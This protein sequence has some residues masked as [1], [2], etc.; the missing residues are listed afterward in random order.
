MQPIDEGRCLNPH[1]TSG[2]LRA[3]AYLFCAACCK[4]YGMPDPQPPTPD[5]IRRARGMLASVRVRIE[6]ARP[7]ALGC[8]DTKFVS[9]DL[10]KIAWLLEGRE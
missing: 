1:C 5:H 4:A 3:D 10:Q 6:N 2:Q 9:D 7:G 8:V